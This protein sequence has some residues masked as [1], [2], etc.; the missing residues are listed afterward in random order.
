MFCDSADFCACCTENSAGNIPRCVL[1]CVDFQP[2]KPD[3]CQCSPGFS[4]CSCS[5]EWQQ[6]VSSP[7]SCKLQFGET[8]IFK[9]A[10]I[11][12]DT[13]SL[14]LLC[15]PGINVE[16]LTW[17]LQKLWLKIESI[18]PPLALKNATQQHWRD[19]AS[20]LTPLWGSPV[21]SCCRSPRTLWMVGDPNK[22]CED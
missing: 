4:D 22:G 15:L 10:L 18:C 6:Y 11:A 19:F 8:V 12:S 21:K 1:P 9:T 7:S 14:A 20:A 2:H 13:S 16:R 5:R 17:R 3:V